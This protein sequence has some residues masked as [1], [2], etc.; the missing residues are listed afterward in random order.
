MRNKKCEK[1]AQD[2]KQIL[3]KKIRN[4][5][6]NF[7][8]EYTN[9]TGWRG[10][11][12]RVV[13]RKWVK[14]KHYWMPIVNE[15]WGVGTVKNPKLGHAT[16]LYVQHTH[17]FCNVVK[18]MINKKGGNG[19]VVIG[20]FGDG[21][22]FGMFSGTHFTWIKYGFDRKWW[23]YN[24]F[25]ELLNSPMIKAWFTIDS[26]VTHNKIVNVPIGVN[27]PRFFEPIVRKLTTKKSV[28][29]S[30]LF[31]TMYNV[32]FT[33]HD[34]TFR[35]VVRHSFLGKEEGKHNRKFN[36]SA[37]QTSFSSLSPTGQGADTY[38]TWEIIL[39]GS[40]PIVQSEG[41]ARM[42][43]GLPVLIVDNYLMG[44][45]NMTLMERIKEITCNSRYHHFEKLTIDYYLNV[46][47]NISKTGHVPPPFNPI[48]Y[49]GPT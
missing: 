46:A 18:H 24:E 19:Y 32:T 27:K 2:G 36:L 34:K 4:M 21:E 28:T 20:P 31:G 29:M 33:P 16:I 22:N 37:I 39:G 30:A 40:I 44:L 7:R 35:A 6:I 9:K 23:C 45:R 13:N 15:I 1:Q 10:F 14:Q 8:S 42:Y 5:V 38:R 25:Y 17:D 12:K 49:Y 41:L 11:V 47:K 43:D 26:P 48:Q 3:G